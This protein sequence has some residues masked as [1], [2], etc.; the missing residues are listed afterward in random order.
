MIIRRLLF[1]WLHV[2]AQTGSEVVVVFLSQL[3]K[4][5]FSVC[6]FYKSDWSTYS[7][8]WW[9]I[10]I[11]SPNWFLLYLSTGV[12]TRHLHLSAELLTHW[13]C[14]A[15]GPPLS[16]QTHLLQVKCL[17]FILQQE[18]SKRQTCCQLLNISGHIISA[19]SGHFIEYST[20]VG[21]RP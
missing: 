9:E 17:N 11:L 12:C 20:P 2:S 7:C 14:S 4:L 3:M 13:A 19:V 5:I 15:S 18:V 16:V 1:Y 21:D 8:R 6:L 10:H